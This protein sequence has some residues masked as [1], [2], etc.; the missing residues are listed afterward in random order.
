VNN[1]LIIVEGRE[2]QCS[3]PGHVS[4]ITFVALIQ[5]VFCIYTIFKITAYYMYFN[6]KTV[7]C[8]T[9][10]RRRRDWY[11]K[12]HLSPHKY[13]KYSECVNATFIEKYK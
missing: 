12:D 2:L 9:K 10:N 7:H 11:K 5:S 6:S 8:A 13:D 1:Y 4:L 3:L